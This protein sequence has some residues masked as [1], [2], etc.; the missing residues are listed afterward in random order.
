MSD[1]DSRGD[2]YDSSYERRAAA[3]EDVHG[4][5]DFVVGYRPGSVLDAGCGTGRVGRE[6]HRRGV[7]VV[8]VD[9]DG[10]MLETARRKSPQVD[11][12]VGDLAHIRLGREFDVVLMAGNVIN[13]AAPA[14]RPQVIANLASH[15]RPGGLLID[16]HSL[17]GGGVS[18]DSYDTWAVEAGLILVE[19]FATWD[20][21]PFR[22]A[23]DWAVSVFRRGLDE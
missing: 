4:E 22:E 21:D 11:W 13:F 16:G 10:E 15:L 5:A 1:S 12:Q 8:G 7:A 9:L 3:G 19:R 17:V 18:V 20:R 2:R 6:L 14:S 23:G